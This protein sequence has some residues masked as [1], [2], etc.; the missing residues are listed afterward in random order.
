[1]PDEFQVIDAMA[2]IAG[3]LP[4]GYGGIGDDVAVVPVRGKKLVL[5]AD[6]LVQ[7]TDMPRDM[8]FRQAARKAAA[9]CVSDFAAKGVRPDA[10]MTS[11]GLPRGTSK[12]QIDQI[13]MGFR[14]AERAWGLRLV[15]GDTNEAKELVID[16]LMSGFG[17]RIVG[18]DGARPGDILVVSDYFGYPPAG[19]LIL[20][21]QTRQ[22]KSFQRQAVRSVL[23]P[24]PS[25]QVGLAI[26]RFLTSGMDSSDGL[27][28]SLHT[29]AKA[30]GVGFEVGKL[31]V[32]PGVIGFA[33][34]NGLPWEK[35]VLAGG[36]EYA[37]VGTVRTRDFERAGKAAHKAGG[38]LLPIG[39]TTSS[40]GEVWLKR[41]DSKDRIADEGW[42]HLA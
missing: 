27:A 30:S 40:K 28:R 6:M 26:A 42:T 34:T 4:P 1:M 2:A 3:R 5:K 10:F 20:A 23:M 36:E 21:G 8:T 18:R 24:T 41:G 11:L 13:G 35:L 17:R 7:S 12:A 37:V 19:L 14:D 16:C 31:P 33:R 29:L 25:L 22:S 9:M 32:G 15:G 38:R 39:T